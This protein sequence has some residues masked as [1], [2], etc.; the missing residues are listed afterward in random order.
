MQYFIV[1]IFSKFFIFFILFFSPKRGLNKT[2]KQRWWTKLGLLWP[3]FRKVQNSHILGRYLVTLQLHFLNFQ[4]L[5][6]NIDCYFLFCELFLL[7]WKQVHLLWHYYSFRVFFHQWR[8]VNFFLGKK[9][10]CVFC[11]TFYYL[12]NFALFCHK[13]PL[14]LLTKESNQSKNFSL[15]QHIHM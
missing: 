3:F 13:F 6:C 8:H 14:L 7:L 1:S 2:W 12:A 15:D 11:G 10:W 9:L 5:L 4:N